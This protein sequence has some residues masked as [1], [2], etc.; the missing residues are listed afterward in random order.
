ML[1]F[2]VMLT[3]STALLS[4]NPGSLY[5]GDERGRGLPPIGPSVEET[6]IAI[7]RVLAYLDEIQS[8]FVKDQ[9]PQPNDAYKVNY[10][11]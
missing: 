4:I 5:A 6:N 3:L 10:L 1:L 8:K 11:V 9:K 2:L 7:N